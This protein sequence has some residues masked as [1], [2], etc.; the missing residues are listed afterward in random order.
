MY[1]SLLSV[2]LLHLS[3]FI[4]GF[5]LGIGVEKKRNSDSKKRR[6]NE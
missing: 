2:M 1:T 6:N 3:F 4:I 5:G